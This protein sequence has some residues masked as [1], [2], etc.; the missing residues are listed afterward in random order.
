MANRISGE[1]TRI[2]KNCPYANGWFACELGYGKNKRVVKGHIYQLENFELHGYLELDTYEVVDNYGVSYA[3]VGESQTCQQPTPI[4]CINSSDYAKIKHLRTGVGRLVDMDAPMRI[5]KQYGSQ[6]LDVI[7]TDADAVK[8]NCQVSDADMQ[9][10]VK[11]MGN[12]S[13]EERMWRI[14]PHLNQKQLHFLMM[15]NSQAMYEKM[16]KSYRKGLEAMAPPVAQRIPIHVFAGFCGNPYDFYIWKQFS[17]E[18]LDD[19]AVHDLGFA[20]NDVRRMDAFLKYAIRTFMRECHAMYV[21]LS[22]ESDWMKF[23]GYLSKFRFAP[24]FDIWTFRQDLVDSSRAYGTN[25]CVETL[26]VNDEKQYHLYLREVYDTQESLRFDLQVRLQSDAVNRP[27]YQKRF[28]KYQAVVQWMKKQNN[29]G[30]NKEQSQALDHVFSHNM[31]IISGGPGR[32]KTFMI[33]KII[34]IWTQLYGKHILMM[35]PTGMSVKRMKDATC[36]DRA[37]TIAWFLLRNRYHKEKGED[38]VDMQ[39]KK[40]PLESK[41]LV[42]VDEM[43]M[44][45]LRDAA[46]MM[47]ILEDCTIVCIGDIHQLPAISP[48]AVLSELIR[49][50]QFSVS[51]LIQNMRSNNQ[52]LSDAC[53]CVLN[54]EMFPYTTWMVNPGYTD[55]FFPMSLSSKLSTL[56]L[57]AECTERQAI[58]AESMAEQQAILDDATCSDAEKVN[59]NF[60]LCQLQA[61]MDSLKA[62]YDRVGI[63]TP[64]ELMDLSDERLAEQVVMAYQNAVST[65]E[66]AKIMLLIPVRKGKCGVNAINGAIQNRMNP[67]Q[68]VTA[69]N[70]KKDRRFG[71]GV[72]LDKRGAALSDVYF[73][74]I[75]VRLGDR[76]MNT[77]NHPEIEW[78]L[79]AQNDVNKSLVDKGLGIYNG[80]RGEIIRCYNDP[81]E[82]MFYMIQFDDGRVVMVTSLELEDFTHSYA[83]TVHKAQGCEAEQVLFVLPYYTETLMNMSSQFL[84]RNLLYTAMTRT[85]ERITLLGSMDMFAYAVKQMA[86]DSNVTLANRIADPSSCQ[87]LRCKEV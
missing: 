55:A 68:K 45:S 49:C 34:E 42:I 8:V 73:D 60:A 72:Y 11:L 29:W 1:I 28:D 31:S 38:V 86:V 46:G 57:Q 25:Y 53:D 62:E 47:R 12:Q 2:Y 39:G 52:M 26:T 77:K 84:T 24:G 65:Y 33:M 13:V 4:F 87:L 83:L 6:M 10:F 30:L 63:L 76:I 70:W 40:L 78:T 61:E 19:V 56:D 74:G 21:N 37:C 82:G 64:A 41:T 58:V 16:D 17:M 59:A 50:Q 81:T 9:E 66:M 23:V 85:R 79:Y 43:S 3:W 15:S 75:N 69:R 36:W 22:S 27:F 35:G 44:V 54:G 14:C 18:S 7:E 48:G 71:H 51:Y 5:Y 67:Y 32:G 20:L 80:D